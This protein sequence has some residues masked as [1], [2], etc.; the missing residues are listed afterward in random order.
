MGI[1]LTKVANLHIFFNTHLNILKQ[2]KM[3]ALKNLEKIFFHKWL[4]LHEKCPYSV[5]FWSAFS[6]IRT[7]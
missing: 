5:L 2:A 1:T 7:E 4:S 3:V 6:S